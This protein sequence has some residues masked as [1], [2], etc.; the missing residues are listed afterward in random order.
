MEY[1]RIAV[2]NEK[3]DSD[4]KVLK[5]LAHSYGISDPL[6]ELFLE[7]RQRSNGSEGCWYAVVVLSCSVLEAVMQ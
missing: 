6:L 5:I 1:G 7:A 4:F 3:T 2:E